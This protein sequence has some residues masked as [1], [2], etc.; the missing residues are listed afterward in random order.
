M[1]YKKDLCP[2]IMYYKIIDSDTAGVDIGGGVRLLWLKL[3]WVFL[4]HGGFVRLV[5]IGVM[6]VARCLV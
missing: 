1:M 5:V 2:K 6:A 4:V 3:C